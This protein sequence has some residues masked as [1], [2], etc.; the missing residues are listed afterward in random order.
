MR[1]GLA[2]ITLAVAASF[3]LTA[4]STATYS[5][6]TAKAVAEAQL[7]VPMTLSLCTHRTQSGFFAGKV[8]YM[9]SC[10][11]ADDT[12]EFYSIATA[13]RHS[14]NL[15]SP[16]M[17]KRVRDI[18]A[19]AGQAFLVGAEQ[20]F[21]NIWAGV[22]KNASLA[23]GLAGAE[24]AEFQGRDPKSPHKIVGAMETSSLC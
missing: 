7:T 3:T 21:A 17:R 23:Q 5:R 10:A 24:T 1:R 18:C 16:Y 4:A 20:K 13:K 8:S 6:A 19:A 15:K 12:F 2:A 22:G 11:N 9:A 14:L